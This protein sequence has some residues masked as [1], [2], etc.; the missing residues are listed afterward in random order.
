[1]K[2]WYFPIIYLTIIAFLGYNYWS[3][4]QT[5][6]A[7]DHL[8]KQL[9]VDYSV[10]DNTAFIKHRDIDRNKNAYPNIWTKQH[11]D[12]AEKVANATDTLIDFINANKT[13]FIQ[14][15]GGLNTPNKD[16]L[17]HNPYSKNSSKSFFDAAKIKE[18]KGKLA[19]FNSILMDSIRDNRDKKDLL[20]CFN[21]PKL[22]ADNSFWNL[23]KMLPAN[24]VLAEFAYIK[25]QI[26]MDELSLLN[27]YAHRTS[28]QDYPPFDRFK[29]VIAPKKAALMEGEIFEADIYLTVFSS[30][31]G[32]NVT[33]KVNGET[34]N[35]K[36]GIA[37]FKGKK[38]AIG[39]KTFKAE[40]FVKNPL[41][42]QTKST[43]GYFEYQVLPQCSRDCQ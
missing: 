13:A 35:I 2:Q 30:N 16:D 12:I 33:I 41:T 18:I 40:A 11:A 15:N 37:H 38:E 32:N 5:F 22:V 39:T 28:G 25:N 1:M 3:S 29:T 20:N 43:E 21:L 23:I 34:L 24:G 42:G 8:N 7:F 17:I 14:L 9:N 6:K 19:E 10:L 26:K 4:V 36:E 31:P 27:Y